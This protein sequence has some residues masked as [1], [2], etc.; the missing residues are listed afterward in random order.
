MRQ[1]YSWIA[2]NPETAQRPLSVP[3][4]DHTAPAREAAQRRPRAHHS[5]RVR[6]C[7]V[8]AAL[9]G[10]APC[11]LCGVSA[12][13]A[14]GAL[15]IIRR[16]VA[17]SLDRFTARSYKGATAGDTQS[18]TDRGDHRNH[19]TQPTPAPRRK[20]PLQGNPGWP[21]RA[22]LFFHN[23]IRTPRAPHLAFGIARGR[24]EPTVCHRG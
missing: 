13:A 7:G 16:L 6:R 11:G 14:W 21:D 4:R 2:W 1:H 17:I 10:G 12:C 8:S 5:Y 18:P 19:P 24:H 22:A 9:S 23:Q 15:K 3:L 20:G